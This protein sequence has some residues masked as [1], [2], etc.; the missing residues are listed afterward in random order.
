MKK[1]TLKK[2]RK[3]LKK[4]LKKSVKPAKK[5]FEWVNKLPF[6][7]NYIVFAII[8]AVFLFVGGFAIMAGFNP[9]YNRVIGY[10]DRGHIDYKVYLKKNSFYKEPY[11]K[12]GMTYV[13]SLIDYLD[14]D[15]AYDLDFNNPVDLDYRYHFVATV[16]A[17]K[18]RSGAATSGKG[19]FLTRSYNLTEEVTDRKEGIRNFSI[20]ER[21][22][23]N[24]DE[25]N[26]FLSDFKAGT[27]VAATGNLK[28]S[29]VFDGTAHSEEIGEPVAVEYEEV[30]LNIPLAES[31]VEA[32]VTGTSSEPRTHT[33]S[34]HIDQNVFVSIFLRTIGV[35]LIIS[36]VLVAIIAIRDYRDN[37][38]DKRFDNTVKHLLSTYDSVI[39]EVDK[40]PKLSGLNVLTVNNFDELL[41][42][43]NSIH[44][45]VSYYRDNIG[46]HFIV[47]SEHMAWR[48]S[49]LEREFRNKK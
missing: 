31:S 39:V 21:L 24:Y 30:Y 8:A 26:K 14:V 48:Y 9:G 23:I 22:N 32:T 13:T 46:A 19:E 15:F 2:I 33:I 29:L 45:P 28:I 16:T 7:L 44:M 36:G 5:K 37:Q 49:I 43:Y 47:I 27:H 1:K 34:R 40:Q 6:K 18:A 12:P 41:D 38:I 20:S 10:S 11:L 3:P 17:D 25:Y 4:P 35:L 42:V